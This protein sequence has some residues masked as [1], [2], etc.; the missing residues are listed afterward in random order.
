MR[1][2]CPE[3]EC[4]RRRTWIK[5]NQFDANRI[6]FTLGFS[7]VARCE[8][9]QES[10]QEFTQLPPVGQANQLKQFFAPR[11]V[12]GFARRRQAQRSSNLL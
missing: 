12:C 7:G 9:P 2:V 3:T 4:L 5:I 10:T 8:V 1:A 11:R 6:C